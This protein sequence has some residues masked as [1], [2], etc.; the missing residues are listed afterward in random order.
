MSARGEGSDL[1]VY[2]E[3]S[4][5]ELPGY[6]EEPPEGKPPEYVAGAGPGKLPLN[7]LH[8]D[9]E[10][11]TVTVNKKMYR[12]AFNPVELGVPDPDGLSR[13]YYI[14][15]DNPETGDEPVKMAVLKI[16]DLLKAKKLDS[17]IPSILQNEGY[18]WGK[19][20]FVCH[21][22]CQTLR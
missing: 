22:D 7:S 21:G 17:E 6:T 8:L 5:E 20:S 12:I 13:K 16:V 4:T 14:I 19:V 10:N 9:E 3:A 11:M 18:Y 15:D 1:P 2:Q